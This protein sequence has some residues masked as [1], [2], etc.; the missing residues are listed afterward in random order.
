MR[1]LSSVDAAEFI[2]AVRHLAS[3]LGEAPPEAQASAVTVHEAQTRCKG[4]ANGVWRRSGFVA[5]RGLVAYFVQTPL[6]EPGC[7]VVR[8]VTLRT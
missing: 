7:I 1:F 5:L 2:S 8:C 3:F 6:S 4:G